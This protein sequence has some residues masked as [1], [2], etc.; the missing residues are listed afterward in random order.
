MNDGTGII[1]S[2]LTIDLPS[3][4]LIGQVAQALAIDSEI[5]ACQRDALEK[6]KD[7]VIH[8]ASGGLGD[9]LCELRFALMTARRFP[10]KQV[11]ILV[12]PAML[13]IPW[14][15]VPPNARLLIW[16]PE[17][18]AERSD[19]FFLTYNYSLDIARVW[20]AWKNRFNLPWDP[21]PLVATMHHLQLQGA[22]ASTAE[23]RTVQANG[24]EQILVKDGHDCCTQPYPVYTTSDL[25]CAVRNWTLG[26]PASTA[27]LQRSVFM[28]G[29]WSHEQIEQPLDLLVAPDAFGGF[30]DS[31]GRSYKSLL[32]TTWSQVLQALPAD[33]SVGIVIGTAHAAYCDI[34]FHLVQRVRPKLKRIVTPTL[35]DFCLR[36]AS[37]RRYIGSDTGTTHIAADLAAADPRESPLTIYALFN[38]EVAD[39][40]RYGIR[41]LGSRGRILVYQ[42]QRHGMRPISQAQSDIAALSPQSITQFI[43]EDG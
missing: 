28:D 15:D 16:L 7:I 43:L 26:I 33:L 12:H 9:C 24:L 10:N 32:P 4:G 35:A 30:L 6:A 20:L 19:I 13:P 1:T 25:L 5:I 31:N 42:R 21:R 18:Y 23:L 41:G 17:D 11:V 36:V 34:V 27:D 8:T 39:L 22:A 3:V 29:P 38:R 14:I 40:S 37:S 2:S